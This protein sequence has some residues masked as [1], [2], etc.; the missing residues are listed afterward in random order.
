MPGETR[1]TLFPIFPTEED[2]EYSPEGWYFAFTMTAVTATDGKPVNA[3]ASFTLYPAEDHPA[4]T[5][6][7]TPSTYYYIPDVPVDYTIYVTNTGTVPLKDVKL[8]HASPDMKLSG[9]PYKAMLPG[10]TRTYNGTITMTHKEWA[11]VENPQFEWTV[12]GLSTCT[13]NEATGSGG[14]DLKA[15]GQ[16]GSPDVRL[17][18]KAIPEAGPFDAG[19]TAT[20]HLF[21][22]NT[23]KEPMGDLRITMQELSPKY[24]DYAR[25][26]ANKRM[27]GVMLQ[28]GQGFTYDWQYEPTPQNEKDGQA[29][30]RYF[31]SGVS[32]ESDHEDFDYDDCVL[33][34]G[35]AGLG[36]MT[37]QY[38]GDFA[39]DDLGDGGIHI[40]GLRIGG[41]KAAEDGAGRIEVTPGSITHTG[42]GEEET[43]VAQILVTNT[44]SLPMKLTHCIAL[45]HGGSASSS[46]IL[47]VGSGDGSYI[48]E[49]PVTLEPN[50][51]TELWLNTYPSVADEFYGSFYR[52]VEVVAYPQDYEVPGGLI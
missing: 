27:N 7:A 22:K 44:G 52:V 15:C 29:L 2:W 1:S 49:S 41:I 24:P 11:E 40:D 46:D 36:L 4:L 34:M 21:V 31:V 51:T 13:G 23:G 39:L 43:I 10:E 38:D 42:S 32:A 20:I 6:T 37:G 19:G 48:D 50:E 33:N 25:R 18:I 35:N 5:V 12:S 30:L 45:N 14:F 47:R 28:P 9:N 17:S 8:L 16:L 26:T 3:S